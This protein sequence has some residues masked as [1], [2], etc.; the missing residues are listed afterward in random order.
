MVQWVSAD[1]GFIAADVIRWK[2]GV[3]KPRKS[4]KGRS[5]RVGE[6]LVIAEVLREPDIKGFVSLLVRGCE[7]ISELPGRTLAPISAGSEV[8]RAQKTIM[9]GKPER[10]L[11]SDETA[12]AL[13]TS[14]FLGNNQP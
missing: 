12:R 2:E 7:I 4:R 9:R 14:K 3:F 8:K 10:L 1:D 5:L 13:L 11:W 6:Q